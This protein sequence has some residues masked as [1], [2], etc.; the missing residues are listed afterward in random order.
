MKGK[1]LRSVF[2][3]GATR[4]QI[5]EARD[6]T[7]LTSRGPTAR[8]QISKKSHMIPQTSSS[9]DRMIPRSQEARPRDFK[10][11]TRHRAC[12]GRRF[13][14]Q[15]LGRNSFPQFFFFHHHGMAVLKVAATM[16]S[17][18][19]TV[20]CPT[21]RNQCSAPIR[22][23]TVYS[24]ELFSL[25]VS[26]SSALRHNAFPA[27]PF[28]V[29]RAACLVFRQDRMHWTMVRQGRESL[30]ITYQEPKKQSYFVSV[31]SPTW[32]LKENVDNFK[33]DDLETTE[34]RFDPDAVQWERK[35]LKPLL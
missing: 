27:A 24:D 9:P 28:L 32:F 19:S 15:V 5:Q 22:S 10:T 23:K 14:L 35:F 21:L 29:D 30:L 2:S 3:R 1:V 6:R 17:R 13:F 4:P 8:S 16:D 34:N 7:I 25:F 18:S 33:S 26:R 11:P 12:F 20:S 31:F